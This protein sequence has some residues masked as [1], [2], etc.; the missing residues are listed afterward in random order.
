MFELIKEF[1]GNINWSI[2]WE[3]ASA[4][5]T[6]AAVFVALWQTR[7]ASKK[8]VKLSFIEK[9]TIIPHGVVGSMPKNQ[10][11]G[12]EIVNTGN[13]KIVINQFWIELPENYRAVIQPD[14]TPAGTV[15]LPVELD[16]EQS[17][18]LPWGREKFLGYLQDE[19][20][21]L[22]NQRLVFCISDS[23]GVTYKCKTTKTVQQYIDDIKK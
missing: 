19:K 7:Y 17:M 8:K 2:F 3:A 18:F 21:L 13:R 15:N 23:A 4:I 12:L 20:V 16:I 14:I 10:Y 6:T 22:R 1:T 9:M 11:V 5:A